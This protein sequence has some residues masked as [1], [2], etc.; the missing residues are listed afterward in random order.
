MI[1]AKLV[2]MIEEHAEQL[3]QSL[4]KDILSNPKTNFYHRFSSE[5]LY[6]RAYD[7]YKNLSEWLIDKT[8]ADIQEKYMALGKQRAEE[9]IPVSQV[10]F[11]LILTRNHLLD[12]VKTFGLADTALDF[13]LELE[14]FY[15]VTQFYDKAIY[16]AVCGY[17]KK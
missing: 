3:T 7:I 2:K 8:E 6:K 13:Y 9:N 11:G 1:S 14:L 12:Y 17:E 10:I 4:V 5:E 15:L 16:F